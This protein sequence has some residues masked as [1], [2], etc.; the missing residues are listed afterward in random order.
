ML[1]T[2]IVTGGS[3]GIGKEI[4]LE[5]LGLGYNVA[6]CYHS[7][8]EAANAL[9][10]EA[11]NSHLLIEKCDVS[12]E[13]EVIKFFEHIHESF[14]NVDYLVNNIGTFIDALIKDF[15]IDDFKHVL[16]V[17]LMGKVIPTKHVYSIMNEGGCIINIS[18]RL[19]IKPCAESAAYCAASAALINFTKA[20]SLE[21]ADKLIRVNSI[22]PSFTPTPL[23]I[24]GWTEE[25]IQAKLDATP[26]KRLSTTEDVAKLCLFLL[27]DDA[28]FI[29]GENIEI[30]GGRL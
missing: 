21:Y 27:S 12:K 2:A 25:E 30:T 18:S 4:V 3:S 15:N 1:K 24:R 5:L 7:N 16:D 8:D 10:N 11:N 20:T 13:E 19:G 14:G 28:S 23:A 29:T 9:K 22:C 17:N 26:L 6:T